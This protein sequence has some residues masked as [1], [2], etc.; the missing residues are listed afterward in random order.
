MWLEPEWIPAFAGMTSGVSFPR[1][2]E[3]MFPELKLDSR[4]RENDGVAI[5]RAMPS[6]WRDPC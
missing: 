4:L 2:R 1:K 3:S 6:T 5:A